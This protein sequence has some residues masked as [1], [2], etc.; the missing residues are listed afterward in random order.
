MH[1]TIPT[2]VVLTL[3]ALPAA[4]Q[5]GSTLAIAAFADLIFPA[6][7]SDESGTGFRVN[8]AEI[9]LTGQIAPD[10]NAAMA[11]AYDPAAETFALAVLTVQLPLVATDRFSAQALVGQF[12]VPFGIDYQVYASVD[13]RLVNGPMI[14]DCTHEGWN[15]L[16]VNLNLALG[17]TGLD[18]FLI[19]GDRCGRGV[20]N[21]TK[22]VD[23][24]AIKRGS[25]GRLHR[26]VSAGLE[27]GISGAMFHD[28]EDAIPMTLLGADF[29]AAWGNFSFKGEVVS[30]NVDRGTPAELTN[31]GYYLQGIHQW[32]KWYA[33]ARFEQWQ[34]ELDVLASPQR[35]CLGAG[36]VVRPGLEVRLEHDAGLQDLQDVTW[37]QLVMDFG[38]VGP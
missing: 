28:Q 9:D 10:L 34:P 15:D 32:E 29:Q 7:A 35:L 6:A 8:Q 20:V 18:L 25:G 1:K 13:R 30:H 3:L 31:H 11:L 14:L 36:L 33:V 26:T 23:R 19:N 12:D 16:G 17:A 37:L 21:P 2:L 38:A 22:E 4:G 5:D 24:S 27:L